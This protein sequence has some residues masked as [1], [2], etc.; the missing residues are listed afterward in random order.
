M[1]TVIRPRRP[2]APVIYTV[3][4]LLHQL[5]DIPP[6]RVLWD[7][8][9]GTATEADVIRYVDAANKRLVELVDGTLVEKAV[10]VH[11]SFLAATLIIFL[12][13][14]VR[15]R[16]LGKVGGADGPLRAR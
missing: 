12:G 6:E 1:S 8:R 16:R 3:A 14:F 10:G 9:P 11:Q 2:A 5:G 15:A 7:P 4:D 13:S